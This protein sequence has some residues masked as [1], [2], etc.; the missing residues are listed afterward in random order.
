MFAEMIGDC[1]FMARQLG[2]P[3][4][5][6]DWGEIPAGADAYRHALI[7]LPE[8]AITSVVGRKGLHSTLISMLYSGDKS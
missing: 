2:F 4:L 5:L 1:L 3:P 8:E 6:F 7:T